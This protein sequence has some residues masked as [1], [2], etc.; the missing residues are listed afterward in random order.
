M[1][2]RVITDLMDAICASVSVWGSYLRLAGTGPVVAHAPSSKLDDKTQYVFIDTPHFQ[3]NAPDPAKER[4]KLCQR[5]K[6]CGVA[7]G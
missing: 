6:R 3:N 4:L 1:S 2:W 5:L 7:P